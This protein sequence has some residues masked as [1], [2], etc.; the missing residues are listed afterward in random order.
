MAPYPHL[1]STE[2]T[3]QDFCEMAA[4]TADLLGPE[5]VGIGSDHHMAFTAHEMMWWTNGRWSCGVPSFMSSQGFLTADWQG[6][7]VDWPS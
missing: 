7:E 3:V 5:H 4:R 1:F 6:E 2:G